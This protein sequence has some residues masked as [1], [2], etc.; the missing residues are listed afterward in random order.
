M[1][2][3][4]LSPDILVRNE[5]TVFIFCRLTAAPCRDCLHIAAEDRRDHR[6]HSFQD[7]VIAKYSVV[8]C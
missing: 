7:R 1:I 6:P 2:S 5:G 8:S 3:D 4:R